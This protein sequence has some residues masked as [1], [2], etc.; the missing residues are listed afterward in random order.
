M[1]EIGLKFT[2]LI[3]LFCISS[4]FSLIYIYAS[5]TMSVF[6]YLLIQN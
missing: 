4:T 2:H 1:V 5:P 6:F 3:S